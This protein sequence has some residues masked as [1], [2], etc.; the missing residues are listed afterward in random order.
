MY[1]AMVVIC[2][3]RLR[4]SATHLSLSVPQIDSLRLSARESES[5]YYSKQRGK[6]RSLLIARKMGRESEREK[7]EEKERERK[8][9][10]PVLN[11]DG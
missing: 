3:M 10:R 5:S 2:I 7:R 1:T 4:H 6:K 9:G 8:A 11:P